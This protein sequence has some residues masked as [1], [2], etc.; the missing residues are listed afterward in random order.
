MDGN[1]AT[2]LTSLERKI[3]TVLDVC[4]GLR[5]ENQALRERVASLEKANQ[6]LTERIETACSRLEDLMVKLPE[7]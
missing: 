2:A 1:L 7:N 4:G 5:A 6:T 3:I